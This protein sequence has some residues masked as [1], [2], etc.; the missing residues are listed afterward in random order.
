MREV[1][2]V[3]DE[4]GAASAGFYSD[5]LIDD[6][7]EEGTLA[8]PR[9]RARGRQAR[10]RHRAR[11]HALLA[12]EDAVGLPAP[13]RLARSARR[14]TSRTRRR[15][16]TCARSSSSRSTRTSRASPS[17]ATAAATCSRWRSRA[18]ATQAGAKAGPARSARRRRRRRAR[19]ATSTAS[20][21]LNPIKLPE[22]MSCLRIRQM[23]PFGNMHVKVSVD[24]I[25]EPR[26]RGLRA[27]RQGRRRRQLRPRGDLPHP[28]AV[29]ALQRQPRRSR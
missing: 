3:F 10:L 2:Y 25:S 27:A 21:E 6:I 15:P 14:S 24:P 5:E 11:H 29:A 8:A 22:I 12:H 17:T 28:V 9:G 13:L 19:C 26:A 1:N 4:D 23:T 16:R 20:E 18:R 7:V